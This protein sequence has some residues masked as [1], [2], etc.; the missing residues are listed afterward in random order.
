MEGRKSS[1]EA[2]GDTKLP[3]IIARIKLALSLLAIAVMCVSATAQEDT[4]DYWLKKAYDLSANGSHE[5]ALQAYDRVLEIDPG[6]YTALINKGH[7]LKFWAFENY[8][9]ALKITNQILEKNPQDALA[10]QGKGAAL[11]GLG[12]VE[13]D[14]AYAKAVE[15]LDNYTKNNPE[16]ASA[17]FLKGENYANMHKVEEALAAYEKV[18]ELNY[19]PRLETAWVTKAVL[20]TELQRFDEALVASEKAILLNPKSTA[21]WFTK[22]YA[23]G[24]LGREDEA[25]AANASAEEMKGTAKSDVALMQITNVTS[26]GE[27]EFIEIANSGNE[28]QSFKNMTLVADEQENKSVV[29]P[30]INLEPSEKIRIHFGRG[31]TNETDLFLNSEISLDDVGG[32][33][34]L[35]D[36]LSGAEKGFMTYWTPASYWLEKGHQL[37]AN[38]SYEEAIIAYSKAT[39]IEPQNATLWDA[40]AASLCMAA[41]ITQNES[42]F[43]ESL[44][45]YDKAIELDPGNTTHQLWKG[46]ALRNMGYGSTRQERIEALEEALQTFDDILKIEPNNTEAWSGKGVIFDD[47][48]MFANDSSKYNDSLAAYDKAIEF[49][50][51]GDNRSLAQA[52]EGKAV[53]LSHMGGDLDKIGKHEE[54]RARYKEAVELYDKV[55]E[56]DPD[57][58]GQEAQQ[59][60]AGVL[61]E[62]GL[63][64][65]S[66]AG[67]K[68]A[69]NRLNQS[70][71]KNPKDAGSWVGKGIL[72][73]EQGY[74]DEA[75]SALDNATKIDPEYVLAWKI[76]GS[77]LSEDLGRSKEALESLDTALGL[78]PAD[79]QAWRD[80]GAALYMM[81]RYEDA[82]KAYDM[83]IQMGPESGRAH[84]GKGDALKVLLRNEEAMKSIDRALEINPNSAEAWGSKGYIFSNMFQSEN[85]T[86]AYE[87][88]L[89]LYE[90]RL[91]QNPRDFSAWIGKGD[92]IG[93]MGLVTNNLSS[94]S[95]LNEAVEA[96]DRAIEINP[97]N[98]KGWFRKGEV[99]SLVAL[100]GNESDTYNQS[101]QA[102]DTALDINPEYAEA[103][104]IKG[105]TLMDLKRYDE[106]AEA[107]EKAMEI[108]P[109]LPGA[110]EGRAMALKELGKTDESVPTA[111]AFEDAIEAYDQTIKAA[112]SSQELSYAWISKGIALYELGRYEEA[113]SAL[114]NATK[115]DPKN[116]MAWMTKAD[117]LASQRRFNESLEAY[118]ETIE[119]IPANST[120]ELAGS[121]FRK[122]DVLLEAN[123]TDEASRAIDEAIRIDPENDYSWVARG[124]LLNKTGRYEEAV[125]AYDEAIEALSSSQSLRAKAISS[126]AW[127]DK[128]NALKA[129]GQE[130]EANEAFV[131]ARELGF[132]G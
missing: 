80:K 31:E 66:A 9:K 38:G 40:K 121:W 43:N 27:D 131:R 34:T 23:L 29:L 86:L 123:R 46:Y 22:G 114:D 105:T 62:L 24:E 97:G 132:K 58:V 4:A 57:F 70:L 113:F 45:A 25:E 11:S 130:D 118:D 102:L 106:S 59:N 110:L 18:I 64:E 91:E 76:K 28:T 99:L 42:L 69:M 21:A 30:D 13:D 33:L 36:Q 72:L 52:Y 89:H 122:V 116:L 100:F 107:F 10:W 17:W 96:F 8:N 5:E 32:N 98:A 68:K 39:E 101:L 117:A 129:L 73:R 112:N 78:D 41:L 71:E 94:L 93:Y 111:Q 49:V 103:W 6:N 7:D 63:H 15:I 67:Y 124:D 19:T 109:G 48:A 127:H 115:A 51:T 95:K 108:A 104:K 35:K 14:Q 85:A 128:G 53:A 92:S 55:I 47:L 88:A 56:L 82:I 50:Q 90:D 61:E 83:A 77:V 84:L 54:A 119:N 79:A 16:N 44:D 87:K 12:S 65:E 20:L 74:Y 125:K 126:K 2:E 75:V 3:G 1:K 26:L 60:R 81:G 120:G 37:S